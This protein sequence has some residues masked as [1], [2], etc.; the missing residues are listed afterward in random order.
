[1]PN[2]TQIKTGLWPGETKNG[3][4]VFK[5]GKPVMILGQKFWVNLWPNNNENPKSPEFDLVLEPVEERDDD[6]PF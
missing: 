6:V 5:A 3:N 2:E 4:L 1:M